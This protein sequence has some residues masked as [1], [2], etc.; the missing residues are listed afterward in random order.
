MIN[1]K[2]CFEIWTYTGFKVLLKYLLNILNSRNHQ[3]NTWGFCSKAYRYIKLFVCVVSDYLTQRLNST[4]KI[5]IYSTIFQRYSNRTNIFP[6]GDYPF[7]LKAFFDNNVTQKKLE[8]YTKSQRIY[9][10]GRNYVFHY[11]MDKE[12]KKNVLKA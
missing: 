9:S 1:F 4:F 8:N 2:I 7:S 6:T 11:K 3:E 5:F 10:S 12:H